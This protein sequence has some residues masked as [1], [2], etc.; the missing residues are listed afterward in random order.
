M[1]FVA[2]DDPLG[3]SLQHNLSSGV[4]LFKAFVFHLWRKKSLMDAH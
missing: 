1:S 3:S 4:V 2:G